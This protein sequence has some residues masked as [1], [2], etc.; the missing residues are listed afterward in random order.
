MK[1]SILTGIAVVLVGL[2]LTAAAITHNILT[3]YQTAAGNLSGST[4][5]TSDSEDNADVLLTGGTSNQV[6]TV[7]LNSSNTL[8]LCLFA[9]Q[10][11]TVQFYNS[12][13]LWNTVALTN[14]APVVAVGSNAVYA[15]MATNQ[16]T[17][18]HLWPGT[19]NCLFSMRSVR[20]LGP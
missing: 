2:S 18:L 10:P 1:K 5:V 6:L 7:W 4:A 19:N 13:T 16:I 12:S 8:S 9:T 11:C 17:A 15:I 14:N 20:H 3:S